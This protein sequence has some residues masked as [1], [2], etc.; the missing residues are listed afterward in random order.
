MWISPV[1]WKSLKICIILILLFPAIA[2]GWEENPKIGKLFN[3]AHIEGT[4]VLYDVNA[5]KIVGYNRSR[6]EM[7][8]SPASTFKIANSLIGLWSSAVENVDEPLPYTGPIEPF[9]PEWANDM[10]LRRAIAISN[11]PIYQEL[12]RRI[13]LERMREGLVKLDYG[14]RET[15]DIVDRFWLDGTLKISV[16]EQINFLAKLAQDKLPLPKKVQASVREI[17]LLNEGADWKLY[18]KT[19]WQNAPGNGIGWWVGWVE[20]NGSFYVFALNININNSSDAAERTK[21][22]KACL[23]LLGLM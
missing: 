19:G 7:R 6:A 2:F 12:A 9:I 21:L 11:V 10:G 3:D 13:G 17:M 1:S 20:K 15:G 16:L 5:D 4:F 8:F 22:G 18:G 23:K 14:N